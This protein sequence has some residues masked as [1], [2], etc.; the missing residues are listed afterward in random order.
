[1]KNTYTHTHAYIDRYREKEGTGAWRSLI[2]SC[3]VERSMM[4]Q[5]VCDRL[6]LLAAG[7]IKNSDSSQEDNNRQGRAALLQVTWFQVKWLDPILVYPANSLVL[8]NDPPRLRSREDCKVYSG[9]G[10][11][12]SIR[13]LGE[14]RIY[15]AQVF[16]FG[17]K[18]ARKY[19]NWY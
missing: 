3:A 10:N 8:E 9:I 16:F 7:W 6:F 14:K 5:C 18:D 1:M 13:T 19:N 15:E 12:S 2:E 4:C 11:C 17:S